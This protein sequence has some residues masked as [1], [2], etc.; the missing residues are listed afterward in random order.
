MNGTIGTL[1]E[2][3]DDVLALEQWNQELARILLPDTICLAV[4]LLIGILGN[5]AVLYIYVRRIRCESRFFIPVLSAMDLVAVIVTCPFSMSINLLPVRFDN[6][7]AC[8]VMWFFAMGTVVLSALT[9]LIIA[10]DRYRKICKPFRK[11]MT[12]KWKRLSIA[13]C[14]IVDIILSL[15]CFFFY[16]SAPVKK[17][18]SQLIGYR[19]TSVT[20]HRSIAA[21]IVKSVYALAGLT[22]WVALIVLYSLIA[23]TLFKQRRK[24]DKKITV[25]DMQMSETTDS[26]SVREEIHNEERQF[27]H[28]GS[29][30]SKKKAMDQKSQSADIKHGQII[31]GFRISVMFMVITA[32]YIVCNLPNL[33]LIVCEALKKDFWQTMS[34]SDIAFFRFLYTMFIINNIANPFIYGFFDRKFQSQLKQSCYR[35]YS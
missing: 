31:P 7:I 14:L 33:S 30:E 10:V 35:N 11:Q 29:A 9:L 19:C 5:S 15:Q 22:V 23:R 2:H 6:D 28:A 1:R 18:N 3:S 34:D 16:G 24:T 17:H 32:V 21:Y 12:R 8:K 25:L 20:G 13:I 27:L 26:T 4:Y